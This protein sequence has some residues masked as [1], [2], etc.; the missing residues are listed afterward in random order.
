[1]RTLAFLFVSETL[2]NIE[3][4]IK[5][6][7][8]TAVYPMLYLKVARGK[9]CSHLKKTKQLLITLQTYYSWYLLWI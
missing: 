2:I 1:M 5:I 3:Q 7:I 8:H 4:Q 6:L 9:Y